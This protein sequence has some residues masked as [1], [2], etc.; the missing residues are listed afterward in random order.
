LGGSVPLL[1]KFPPFEKDSSYGSEKLTTTTD[2]C[3]MSK[4]NLLLEFCAKKKKN[5]LLEQ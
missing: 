3:L 2:E 4:K 1:G 5:L